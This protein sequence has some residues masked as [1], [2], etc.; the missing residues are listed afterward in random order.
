M[1]GE[2]TTLLQASIQ[3]FKSSS[4][5]CEPLL[6]TRTQY[7]SN[8]EDTHRKADFTI[9]PRDL[10]S[11]YQ[12][13]EEWELEHKKIKS[14]VGIDA[15]VKFGQGGS[16]LVHSVLPRGSE[17]PFS[18]RN[19]RSLPKLLDKPKDLLR[20][21]DV[22][23]F[24]MKGKKKED[25]H[26]LG[27]DNFS[28]SCL[29]DDWRAYCVMDGHGPEGHWASTHAV[30]K[31]PQYLLGHICVNMLKQREIPAA[32]KFAFEKVQQDL[33]HSC[34]A[35][36]MSLFLSG[37]T[38]T[39]ALQH[40]RENSIWVA[41]VGDSRAILVSADRGLVYETKDHH[42]TREKEALRIQNCGGE[43]RTMAHGKDHVSTRVYQEG[44]PYPGILMTRSL[45]DMAAK[46]VGVICEPEVVEWPLDGLTRPHYFAASDGIWE[47]MPST[48]VADIL[49]AGLKSGSG[50]EVVQKIVDVAKSRWYDEEEHYCDDI[51]VVL[52]PI[53]SAPSPKGRARPATCCLPSVC[54]MSTW[55][56]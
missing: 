31:V 53:T 16:W 54:S 45:G 9:D 40:P 12:A 28:V 13:H 48:E 17:K 6:L 39:C 56:G 37:S 27:Q 35:Q 19:L 44:R 22:S 51:T 47:F 11:L 2:R 38:A 46:A 30:H 41:T 15:E 20:A 4:A 8:V 43:V 14:L 36:R 50:D 25:D 10:A 52:V 26:S 55:Y 5:P 49:V 42:P 29:A 34:S 21:L 33:A 18:T 23:V 24:G 1:E 3:V 32:L 7:D